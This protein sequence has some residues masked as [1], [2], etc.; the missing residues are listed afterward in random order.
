MRQARR[1]AD[2]VHAK[3]I[4]MVCRLAGTTPRGA[5]LDRRRGEQDPPFRMMGSIDIQKVRRVAG[6]RAALKQGLGLSA[7]ADDKLDGVICAPRL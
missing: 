6:R 2:P 1:L 3:S 5:D 4:I 7:P